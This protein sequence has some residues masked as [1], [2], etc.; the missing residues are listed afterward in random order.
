[1]I[2]DNI[3]PGHFV[4][5]KRNGD[6]IIPSILIKTQIKE[7]QILLNVRLLWSLEKT[8]I[9]LKGSMI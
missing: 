9:G 5:I 3:K 7:E 4:V 1:M 2:K 8:R 6:E